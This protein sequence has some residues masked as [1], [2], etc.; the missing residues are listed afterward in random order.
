QATNFSVTFAPTTGGNFTG[1][2][3]VVSSATNSPLTESLSGTGIHWTQLTWTASMGATGYNVYR[4]SSSSSSK[5]N[6]CGE[7]YSQIGSTNGPSYQDFNVTA[8]MAYCYVTAAVGEGGSE[9]GPSNQAM[10]TIPT[11]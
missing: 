4:S 9:S 7:T 11:P 8:G 6:M 2:L 3:T 1:T 5:S 10:V